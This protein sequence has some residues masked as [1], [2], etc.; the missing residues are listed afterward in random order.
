MISS[1]YEFIKTE[2]PKRLKLI[3]ALKNRNNNI[4]SRE[5]WIFSTYLFFSISLLLSVHMY[6][7]LKCIFC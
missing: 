1:N 4:L 6:E 3:D 7:Y 2:N 5:F